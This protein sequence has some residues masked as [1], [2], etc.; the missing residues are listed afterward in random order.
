MSC[1]RVGKKLLEEVKER[2]LTE[3]KMK[4]GISTKA[5]P[6]KGTSSISSTA[7]N[8]KVT[9]APIRLLIEEDQIQIWD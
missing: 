7:Q 4:L 2:K 3:E 8:E 1:A 6:L 5:T 9:L